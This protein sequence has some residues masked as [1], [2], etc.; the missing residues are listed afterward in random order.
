MGLGSFALVSLAEARDLAVRYRKIAR[1]GGDPIQERRQAQLT[2]PTFAEAA[3]T[4]FE[5]NRASW[6]NPK[7]A[8]QWINT[9]ETYAVPVIGTRPVSDVETADILR[10]LAPIWLTKA[11]T[12]RRV[13]Q[14][15]STVFDWAK[16]AGFRQG[17]NPVAGADRGLPRQTVKVSHHKALPYQELPAFMAQLRSKDRGYITRLALEF[18]ILTASRTSEVLNAQWPEFD[19]TGEV[20]IVPATRMKAGREHRVPLTPRCVEIVRQLQQLGDTGLVFPGTQ[21]GKAM[22]NMVFATLLRRM[23]VDA[24]VH[25]FRSS[26]RDWVAEETNYPNELAEMALAHTI[27]NATEAAYRRGDLLERRRAMMLAWEVFI[28][29]DDNDP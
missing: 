13:R 4:V 25:G 6:R 29:E 19:L 12:A 21:K 3:R 16:A 11:E 8:Q 1:E 23:D 7:H 22:S 9:L 26:F 15:L 10:V 2:V 17:D 27:K 14:R 5:E 28:K 20:W 24:T 18:L